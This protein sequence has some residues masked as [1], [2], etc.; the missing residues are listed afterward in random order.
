MGFE[1]TTSTLAKSVRSRHSEQTSTFLQGE[2]V[3]VGTDGN[4]RVPGRSQPVR[5][6]RSCVIAS[7]AVTVN[8]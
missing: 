8:D 4:V 3:R 6:A 7:A 1:P 5:A 2:R